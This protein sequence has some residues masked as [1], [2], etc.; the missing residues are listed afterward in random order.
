MVLGWAPA[1][2][3]LLT[4]SLS[5]LGSIF[6]LAAVQ[7]R[8]RDMDGRIFAETD[9]GTRYLGP[10]NGRALM[11]YGLTQMAAGRH[12]IAKS[13]FE[14]AL[15]FTPPTRRCRSTSGSSMVRSARTTGPNGTSARQ[16]G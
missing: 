5:A 7:R 12:A 15:V 6:I 8:E 14:R 1:L 4:T 11:N 10:G 9:G 13:Y 2:A 3:L 16:S